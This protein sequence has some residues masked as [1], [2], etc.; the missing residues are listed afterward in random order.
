[1]SN[2]KITRRQKQILDYIK[3][4]IEKKGYSPSLEDITKHFRLSSIATIHEHIE[5]LKEKGFLTS[6]KNKPYS[7]E[8]VEQKKPEP[9]LHLYKYQKNFLKDKSRFKMWL[10]A[11]QIGATFCTTLELVDDCIAKKTKWIYLSRGERQSKEAIEE[12]KKHAEAYG[13]VIEYA[14]IPWEDIDAKQLE[15]RFPNGSKIIGLPAKPETARGFSGNVVLDEFAFHENPNKIW[16]ALVPTITRGYRLIILSTPNG[17]SGKFY[18]LWNSENNY[19][20]HFLTIHQAKEQGLNVDIDELQKGINDTDAW[21]QEYECQFVDKA[22]ALLPYELIASVE[23]ESATEKLPQN[24]QAQGPLFLG[25]DIGRVKDLT[26]I[27]IIER[28]GDVDWTRV[29]H[30]IEKAPFR[31]QREIL[32]QYMK[33][34]QR[35]CIDQTGI[36]RQLAEEAIEAY[37]EW[38]VEGITMTMPVNDALASRIRARLD[39]RLIRIPKNTNIREDLHSIEKITTASGHHRY[40]AEKTDIGHADRFWSLALAENAA[41]TEVAVPRIININ[42]P[43]ED[44]WSR[45]AA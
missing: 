33:M 44:S 31:F 40:K 4:F 1:M 24:F 9:I 27:W 3:T 6:Q 42:I 34:V 36:G 15:I 19:S 14:E 7:I 45:F 17:G 39:D 10:K 11:R 29:V 32:F 35:A 30:I 5:N 37:G 22:R 26:V 25:M 16:T 21:A 8:I 13:Q 43:R 18:E 20:K 41:G 38:K 2:V 12:A 23:D 28:L